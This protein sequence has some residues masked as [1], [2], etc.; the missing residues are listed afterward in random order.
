MKRKVILLVL[1]AGIA[2]AVIYVRFFRNPV[3][4]DTLTVSGNIEATDARLGFRIQG[5]LAQRLV[6]EGDSVIKGQVLARLDNTDQIISAALAQASLDQSRAVL[7]ELE[8]GSRPQEISLAL[9]KVNQAKQA[10]LELTNGSRPQE[11]DSARAELESALEAEKS[12][13]ATLEQARAD[14]DRYRKL[15]ME[16]SVS[17]QSFEAYTT[18]Y[19]TAGHRYNEA[20]ARVDAARQAL[21]L[22]TEGPRKEKVRMASY[23]L[24][25]AQAQYE[26]VRQGPR[27]EKIDL[28]RA[29]VRAAEEVLNQARQQV[30]YTDLAAPMDGVVLSKS[31]EPG[32]YLTPGSPVL[33]LGD[34]RNPWLRAYV[35]EKDLG[36]VRLKQT[37]SV[38]TDA[39]PGRKFTGVVSF[40]S[41]QAEFTPK[42]VQTFEERVKLMYRI[43]ISLD[44][45]DLELKPGMPADAVIPRKAD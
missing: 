40:I 17:E 1:A 28:A 31:A 3:A 29:Q 44:N 16:K 21:S 39:F 22:R 8:A 30:R 7:A 41:S 13:S 24:D 43:R 2:G 36:A 10:L 18:Q 34:I 32:E 9:A 5:K 15:F 20:R 26:L 33:T 27:Q 14:A 38:V 23:A 11:I 35:N 6:D 37:V 4:T 12:A 19:R 42:S 25:E 45:P